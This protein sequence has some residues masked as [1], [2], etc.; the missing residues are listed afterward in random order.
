MTQKLNHINCSIGIM[1]YNEEANIGMLLDALLKQKLHVCNIVEIIVVASGCSD[2]TEGIVKNYMEKDKR[3]KLLIQPER[4][5]KASAI[6]LFLQHSKGEII[7]LESGDTLPEQN[8]IE[9]LVRPF[10]NPKVGMTGAHPVPVNLETTFIG[11]TV[12][13]L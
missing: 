11:F 9:N 3:I 4:Q 7:V 13:L 2:N 6:N 12:N 1:A 5:G 10:I 8:T